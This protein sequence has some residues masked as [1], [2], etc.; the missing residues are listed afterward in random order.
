M[1]TNTLQRGALPVCFIFNHASQDWHSKILF[2]DTLQGRSWPIFYF[3]FIS[4]GII[5]Q[6]L[7]QTVKIKIVLSLRA[8]AAFKEATSPVLEMCCKSRKLASKCRAF[9]LFL[10]SS[11][12]S[13]FILRRKGPGLFLWVKTSFSLSLLALSCHR[14]LKFY[15]FS[16][17]RIP[18]Q[19][20]S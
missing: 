3:S 12:T 20:I 19:F 10:N 1:R 14:W 4:A 13:L 17:H 2:V 7:H 18:K 9:F 5:V 16:S 11:F 6:R 8:D 15:S